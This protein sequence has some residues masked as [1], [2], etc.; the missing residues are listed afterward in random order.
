MVST[1]TSKG[2]TT[3]PVEVRRHLRLKPGDKVEFVIDE[4]GN[5]HL[6]PVRYPT[7][8]SLSGAAGKLRSPVPEQDLIRIAREETLV[9][10][11]A[12]GR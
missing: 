2:Q 7:V 6:R 12:N 1:L 9:A 5:V 4:Q 11:H 3:I 8:A 10:K